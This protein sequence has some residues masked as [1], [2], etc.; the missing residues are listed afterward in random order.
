MSKEVILPKHA[1]G[2]MVQK[3]DGTWDILVESIHL[4]KQQICTIAKVKKMPGTLVEVVIISKEDAHGYGVIG[5]RSDVKSYL[6]KTRQ[7]R[8]VD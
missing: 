5:S 4:S 7:A 1:Y 2:W 8:E 3:D 6:D